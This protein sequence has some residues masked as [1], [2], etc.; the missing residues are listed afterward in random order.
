MRTCD[1]DVILHSPSTRDGIAV[2]LWQQ[3]KSDGQTEFVIH[4]VIQNGEMENG[5]Y[6]RSIKSAGHRYELRCDTIGVDYQ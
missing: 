1:V 5:F 6:T 3:T 2:I 4:T